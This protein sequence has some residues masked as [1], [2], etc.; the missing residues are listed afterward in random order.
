MESLV[1][2]IMNDDWASLGADIEKIVS[3]KIKAKV[4]NEKVN[5]LAKLN[6]MTAEQMKAKFA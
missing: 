2:R 4:D 1:T 3:D 5:V 6:N